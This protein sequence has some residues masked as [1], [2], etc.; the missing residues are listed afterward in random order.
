MVDPIEPSELDLVT[1]KSEPA[2]A[3]IDSHA[4]AIATTWQGYVMWACA[5]IVAIILGVIPAL[6]INR[7]RAD[8]DSKPRA[9][10]AGEVTAEPIAEPP[11]PVTTPAAPPTVPDEIEVDEPGE[12]TAKR[13]PDRVKR[14]VSRP[15][16]R[17]AKPGKTCDV[18]LHP[19][20]CPR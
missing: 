18:Y 9:A 7:W 14:A 16:K 2:Q 6:W 15:A 12:T 20:G 10:A 11:A 3:S 13:K 19:H 4:Y 17:P 5:A 1:I 8:A